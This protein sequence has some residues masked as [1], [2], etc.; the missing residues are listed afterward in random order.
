M[1]C[2]ALPTRK[3]SFKNSLK[4][5]RI[6][7]NF[8]S[9]S[10]S[11]PYGFRVRRIPL[12]MRLATGWIAASASQS[13]CCMPAARPELHASRNSLH[14]IHGRHIHASSYA[15][16][17]IHAFETP[18]ARLIKEECKPNPNRR[19]IGRMRGV[20][21]QKRVGAARLKRYDWCVVGP[22]HPTRS[23]ASGGF[24]R[25]SASTRDA[26]RRRYSLFLFRHF[27]RSILLRAASLSLRTR[28]YFPLG[29]ISPP[30]ILRAPNLRIGWNA[31]AYG[32]FLTRDVEVCCL[33]HYSEVGGLLSPLS[34]ST[35]SVVVAASLYT[36]ERDGL[37]TSSSSIGCATWDLSRFIRL[38]IP[39]QQSINQ[40][41]NLIQCTPE[42]ATPVGS[43][44]ILWV[45]GE[46]YQVQLRMIRSIQT[47][48]T[49]KVPSLLCLPE[50]GGNEAGW[51]TALFDSG[52]T[53]PGPQSSDVL[54]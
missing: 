16:P 32:E 7:P 37:H 13:T 12:P 26:P 15:V 33:W 18:T 4:L 17:R 29:F 31:Q 46:S 44:L 21:L 50:S 43:A 36:I 5:R 20:R 34:S 23:H 22:Y 14:H 1:H 39:S 8:Y 54:A 30:R 3:L 40:P 11:K 35:A 51:H 48:S 49:C 10:A 19:W 52:P 53:D 38:P 25:R 42:S 28:R 27:D 6:D 41:H 2:P 47:S 9:F 24:P 45:K